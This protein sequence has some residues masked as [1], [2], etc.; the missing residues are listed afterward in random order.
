[1]NDPI[2]LPTQ[3]SAPPRPNRWL[4]WPGALLVALGAIGLIG[5]AVSRNPNWWAVFILVPAIGLLA[6]AVAAH[7]RSHGA[8]NLWVR[9]GLSSGL[10]VLAVAL[11]FAFVIDWSYAWTL[12]LIVPGLAVFLNGFTYPRARFGTPAG[13]AANFLFWLGG[14]VALLGVT[15]LVDSLGLIDLQTLFGSAHWWSAFILLPGLGALINAFAIY[16]NNGGDLTATTLLAIGVVLCLEAR[17][18]YVDMAWQWRVPLALLLCGLTYL[19]NGLVPARK[20]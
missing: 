18:E 2:S 17:A 15:F 8:Y 11:I 9:L 13:S 1:M 19:A 12:M 5:P 6:G 7:R 16:A 20:L 10:I 14:S 3:F 4:S